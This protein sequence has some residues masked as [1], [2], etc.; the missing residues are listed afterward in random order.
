MEP[1]H[2]VVRVVLVASRSPA[3]HSSSSSAPS[4]SMLTS[5]NPKS[6]S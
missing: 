3:P 5:E 6:V 1:P 4:L 2:L